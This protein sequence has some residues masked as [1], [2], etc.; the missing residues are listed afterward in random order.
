MVLPI[1]HQE[2][3]EPGQNSGMQRQ[4]GPSVC[5]ISKGSDLD[6]GMSLS[7][8]SGKEQK[9]LSTAELG[10]ISPILLAWGNC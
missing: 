1:S 3:P 7:L 2:L 6:V 5:I 4:L 8:R 10:L 9:T